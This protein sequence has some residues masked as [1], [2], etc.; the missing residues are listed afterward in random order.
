M[1]LFVALTGNHAFG[2]N[3]Y[4]SFVKEKALPAK[5]DNNVMQPK[6]NVKTSHGSTTLTYQIAG[7]MVAEITGMDENEYELIHIKGFG[8]LGEVGN[9]A[10]P[11]HN[12]ILATPGD[13]KPVVEVLS[14]KFVEYKDYNIHPALPPAR[15]TE[16]KDQVRFEKNEKT[17]ST[18]SFYPSN[19]V[20]IKEVLEYRGNYFS[21]LRICPVQYNPVTKT[22]R[23]YSEIS[24]KV[25][26]NGAQLSSDKQAT[27]FM[28]SL[29]I[30]KEAIKSSNLKGSFGGNDPNYLIIA[31]SDFNEA[32]ETLARW[33]AQLGYRTEII[34]KDTWE[35]TEVK[36]AIHTRFA[37]YQPAPSYFVIIGDHEQVPGEILI[38]EDNAGKHPYASDLY[39][40][41]TGGADDYYPDM[42]KGRISANTPQQALMIVN[43]GVQY[44]KMPVEDES[45]YKNALNCAQFQMGSPDGYAARRF[46]HTSEELRDYVTSLGYNV[47]RVYYTE[48]NDNPTNYNNDVY[49]DGQKIPDELLRSNG[50]DWDGNASDILDEIN[51]G[52]FYVLHRDH[53]FEGGSGW[54]HPEFRVRDVK[55][56]KNGNK[57]PVVF[58]LNCH[59]GEFIQDECF[60]ESFI[61][62]P[63]GGAVGVIAAA[64]YSHSG[65]NDGLAV[66]MFDAIWSSPGIRPNFGSGGVDPVQ[67][68]PGHAD[69]ILSMGD[70][71]NQGLIRMRETWTGHPTNHIYTHRLFHYFGDPALKIRTQKPE[72]ITAT[73]NTIAC[74]GTTLDVNNISVKSGVITLTQGDS[75]MAR[76][77]LTSGSSSLTFRPVYDSLPLVLTISAPNKIPLVEEIRFTGCSN[78]PIPDFTSNRQT[79]INTADSSYYVSF[80]NKT[81]YSADSYQWT[82]TPATFD[83]V[84]GTGTAS[85]APVVKFNEPGDYTIRLEATNSNG[86]GV[87]TKTNYINVS[88]LGGVSCKPKTEELNKF[89]YGIY[90]FEI[91]NYSKKSGGTVIDNH[92]TSAGYMDFT[93]DPILLKKGYTADFKIEVGTNN[94]ENVFMFMDYNN[95]GEFDI[96]SEKIAELN[97]FTGISESG[98]LQIKEQPE[99]EA[100]RLRLISDRYIYPIES[101]CHNPKRGQVEDYAVKF[102]DAVPVSEVAGV[103]SS[104]FTSAVLSAK[105]IT[106]GGK[107]IK[108]E[109]LIYTTDTTLELS[110]WKVT[111]GTTTDNEFTVELKGLTPNT[112]Y[113]AKSYASNDV[114]TSY[115]GNTKAFSTYSDNAPTNYP[116][117]FHANEVLCF[118]SELHWT[119]PTEGEVL[120]FGYIIKRSVEGFGKIA[121]PVDGIAEKASDS[122]LIVQY[123]ENRIMDN[124]LKDE[125][126]YYY[127]IY[128]YVNN[129]DEIKYKTDGDVPQIE[130]LTPRFGDYTLP[131]IMDAVTMDYINFNTIINKGKRDTATYFDY[132][133]KYE[134][135]VRPGG[136][137]KLTVGA[138]PGGDYEHAIVAWVDWNRNGKFEEGEEHDLGLLTGKGRKPGDIIVPESAEEGWTT[139]RVI[140]CYGNKPPISDSVVFHYGAAEDYKI[141]VDKNALI[142]GLWNGSVSTEW[143]DAGNWDDSK[144]PNEFTTV[145][146]PEGQFPEIYA[147]ARANN[148]FVENNSGLFIFD[149][150]TEV[151]ENVLISDGA[152]FYIAYGNTLINNDLAIGNGESGDFIME[153]GEL[154]I[155]GNIYTETNC[156]VDIIDGSLTAKNWNR[157]NVE[158][159]SGGI[160]YFGGGTINVNDFIFS[161]E[162][163][164]VEIEDSPVFNITGNFLNSSNSFFV[165]GGTFVFKGKESIV[166]ASEYLGTV[167]AGDVIIEDSATV[168]F[169][170][171]SNSFKSR[172]II[173]GDFN[174]KGKGSFVNNGYPC[175]EVHIEGNVKVEQGG[176]LVTGAAIHYLHKDF[177]VE[178]KL[179]ANNSNITILGTG[180]QYINCT[181][182]IPELTISSEAGLILLDDVTV[183]N[184]LSLKGSPL[185]LNGQVLTLQENAEITEADS[186]KYPNI[187]I[188]GQEGEIRKVVNE[189]K[190]PDLF[191]PIGDTAGY[192]PIKAE[193]SSVT[194]AGKY[195]SF[196]LINEANQLFKKRESLNRAWEITTQDGFGQFKLDARLKYADQ[197]V[198]NLEEDKIIPVIKRGPG[199]FSC[200]KIHSEENIL[201]VSITKGGIITGL[202]LLPFPVEFE[203]DF[204]NE[205]TKKK[206]VSNLEYSIYPDFS[207]ITKAESDVIPLMPGKNIFI[208]KA[209]ND[210][211]LP[212]NAIAL[213]VPG[214]PSKPELFN[215]DFIKEST[216]EEVNENMEYSTDGFAS[217]I[218]GSGERI[219][220]KPSIN[221]K[222]RVKA[223]EKSFKSEAVEL[224]VPARPAAPTAQIV[225]DVDNT[226]GFNSNPDYTEGSNYEVS[227]NGGK[228]WNKVTSIPI[229]VGNVQ[230]DA[231]ELQVR[232]SASNDLEQGRFSGEPLISDAGFTQSASGTEDIRSNETILYPNPSDGR[233]F[234]NFENPSVTK[235]DIKISN[236]DGQVISS[237]RENNLVNPEIDLSGA[238]EGIYYIQLITNEFSIIEKVVVK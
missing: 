56:L 151:T 148:I 188:T 147:S 135:I 66:G 8:K 101:G 11:A 104:D 40:A 39:Y 203:I 111:G 183:G 172:V 33:K 52:K 124:Q 236:A 62:Q 179:T 3:K 193:L 199:W 238:K 34:L 187:I 70:V 114:G 216:V 113:Y 68:L 57:L 94:A 182:I 32:A 29:I 48:A 195:I 140:Y 157:D 237:Y 53:G 9:P 47:N 196:K 25:T 211:T 120:P 219:K 21:T 229:R 230:V 175:W 50:F 92:G 235:L 7:G 117:G 201:S 76:A 143:S 109:G 232:V 51:Q 65:Y 218:S 207:V 103:N 212:T 225:N 107:A 73:F 67:V 146:I 134:T 181:D 136:K 49:S 154:N 43:K 209:G 88:F 18:D 233:V 126:K 100:V 46:C 129:G 227:L 163:S 6:R 127:K 170:E 79:V 145:Q 58:S 72:A 59:T 71:L 37:N 217:S 78:L 22:I 98:S 184:K 161:A 81:I 180:K 144:V 61:R 191:L 80:T 139:M 221:I 138:D 141:I 214:R 42:A 112:R 115:S 194:P 204:A 45:F 116:E 142:P 86:S 28:K 156:A 165:D 174:I 119:P 164:L 110:A 31:R 192:L 118:H 206:S 83:Y 166:A 171:D 121:P 1:A 44:E 96:N 24:Y 167:V 197:D 97:K 30:N 95:D 186:L 69:N 224:L 189:T 20:E 210:T 130:I 177:V 159:Y 231:G 90:S 10:L 149:G 178:G 105:I 215:I 91:D 54:V 26:Y 155:K 38:R 190:L 102:V 220:L 234:I 213:K 198:G 132:R 60:A 226:F 131:T 122:V 176:E 162:N 205:T 64:Y 169:N 27:A 123:G 137:Y 5:T 173:Q 108:E 19:T 82:I 222:Y 16:G 152:T 158:Q 36:D 128:P 2:Q 160:I 55:R 153:G 85:K 74:G 15:D 77:D 35:S 75:L 133:D 106:N 200:G 23:V 89:T 41:C 185:F 87:E 208:R 63:N 4:L 202:T 168:F 125:T 228:Q 150:T 12:D 84:E 17:Y 14:S 99:F 93:D 13:G 223:T